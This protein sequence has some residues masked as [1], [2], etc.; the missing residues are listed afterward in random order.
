MASDST[1]LVAR[2]S[3]PPKHDHSKE[4]LH[5]LQ[6]RFLFKCDLCIGR[7]IEMTATRKPYFSFSLNPSSNAWY[8][9]D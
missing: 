3:A 7:P 9:T 2:V 4:Q 8:H 6:G 1:W 5:R